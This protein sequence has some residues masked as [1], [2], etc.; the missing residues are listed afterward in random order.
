MRRLF[1]VGILAVLLAISACGED[2]GPTSPSPGTGTLTILP[3]TDFLT[4]GSSVTFQARLASDSTTPLPVLAEWSSEDGRIA[5]V[6]RQGRVTALASGTTTI[7]AF[8]QG[9]TATRTIRVAPGFAGTWSGPRRVAGCVHPDPLFCPANF[10]VGQQV[11]TRV[12]LT[13][14]RDQ[15]T[16]TFLFAPPAATPSAAVS[17][18]IA[19]DGRLTLSGPITA[20][21][22]G[23]ALEPVGTLTDWRV[24]LDPL[25]PI[26]RGGFT[27][28]RTDRDGTSWRVT[29]DVDGLIKAAASPPASGDAAK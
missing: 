10:P 29:W 22:T 20:P 28:Q 9:H 25:Q 4:I 2:S 18:V 15:V 3:D 27:E 19:P 7:R 8:Y 12:V 5:A 1:P 24:D 21:G 26:L 6:D 13:Q 14:D 17:G 23:V 11:D 16:G